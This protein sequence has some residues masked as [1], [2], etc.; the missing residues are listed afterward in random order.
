MFTVKTVALIVAAGKSERCGGAVPKQFVTIAGKPLLS[1][2]ISRFEAATSIDE[3]VLVVADNAMSIVHQMVVA[4][5]GF[6]KVKAI[7][8]GGAARRE[9][10]SLGLEALGAATDLVAIHD[11]ARPLVTPE[12][13]DA[14]VSVARPG[15]AA[16]LAVPVGDTLKR[17]G[18]ARILAT[19]DRSDIY[20][21]QTPQVFRYELIRDLHR[22]VPATA[23]G[24]TDDACLAEAAGH[25]VR[26]VVPRG[27]NLKVTT[28]QDLE[29]VAAL[30]EREA[31]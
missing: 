26:V 10:V 9:S 16:I 3:I 19:L 6:T 25:S 5:F 11:G 22:A 21:A 8:P 17:V 27:N 13:I 28:L 12:D 7:V 20:S 30:L 15:S 18:D 23:V 2:T 31:R 14:V 4:P 24:V 1:W 29:L